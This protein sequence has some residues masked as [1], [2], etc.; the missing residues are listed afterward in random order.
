MAELILKSETP[1]L[2][3]IIKLWLKEENIG[4]FCHEEIHDDH[5]FI[6]A[7]LTNIEMALVSTISGVTL[8]GN[9]SYSTKIHPE[10]PEFFDK[11]RKAL[12]SG[13]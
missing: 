11:L 6:V 4:H 5:V 10:D 12:T 2:F 13:E 9:G 3:D 8:A 1:N 7:K